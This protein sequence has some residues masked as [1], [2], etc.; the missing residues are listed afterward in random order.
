MDAWDTV[1]QT[2][3]Q[4]LISNK[5]RAAPLL[6][7]HGVWNAVAGAQTAWLFH[8]VDDK[9]AVRWVFLMLIR[10]RREFPVFAPDHYRDDPAE[11]NH[12]LQS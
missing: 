2:P 7:T 9:R 11:L 4:E 10:R 3:R 12:S 1:A 8:V 6:S 5:R